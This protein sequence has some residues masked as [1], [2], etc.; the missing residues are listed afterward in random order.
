[1]DFSQVKNWNIPEGSVARVKD[2][3]DNVI[4]ENPRKL[5]I[6]DYGKIS[7]EI[8][9]SVNSWPRISYDGGT[10]WNDS[11]EPTTALSDNT[12]ACFTIYPSKSF[13]IKMFYWDVDSN[14]WVELNTSDCTLDVMYAL[15]ST[16]ANNV[17]ETAADDYINSG[18]VSS[19]SSYEDNDTW[20]SGRT[21]V[22]EKYDTNPTRA[23]IFGPTENFNDL[24]LSISAF[25]ITYLEGLSWTLS[26]TWT[27]T[28]KISRETFNISDPNSEG[29][30]IECSSSWLSVRQESGTGNYSSNYVSV[31]K[32]FSN[33]SRTGT[34]TLKDSS[35]TVKSTYT[36]TQ[37]A[38]VWPSWDL[39]TNKTVAGPS[40]S[41]RTFDITITDSNEVG[42]EITSNSNNITFSS[43]SGNG[44]TTITATCSIS[45]ETVTIKLLQGP[46]S[47]VISTCTVTLSPVTTVGTLSWSDSSQDVY[48]WN[49]ASA[50][51][52]FTQSNA[53][54]LSVSSSASWC[55]ASISG[56][57]VNLTLAQNTTSSV[58]ST[59][60]TLSG[61]NAVSI[62]K[63]ISQG[64]YDSSSTLDAYTWSQQSVNSGVFT[65]CTEAE[66]I[67]AGIDESDRSGWYKSNIENQDSTLNT[68]KI[69]FYVNTATNI[70]I[71]YFSD[72]ETKYD[73]LVA[74]AL[75]E[76]EIPSNSDLVDSTKSISTSGY[77]GYSN[78]KSVQYSLTAG[79]HWIYVTYLKDR[80]KGYGTD[81]GYFK[82]C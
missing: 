65:E 6:N 76:E 21:D 49:T 80:S 38:A 68:T 59:T 13:C 58:R 39:G 75:D 26:N 77:Q 1:M 67:A 3:N 52:S 66:M 22:V 14:S 40:G 41:V 8:I 18:T 50:T 2:S 27:P 30:T 37:G 81:S 4:W 53:G 24:V 72:G 42:W 7:N 63:T 29:W 10:T 5:W 62:T 82:I 34:I 17:Y 32:N 64:A 57:T 19:I 43:A 51:L 33:T 61:T 56:N 11:E 35:G 69:N 60:I 48:Y 36:I 55:S 78:V 28:Y 45:S 20:L 47:T 79:N 9:Y 54:T 23:C 71:K 74:T 16:D 25:K 12:T 31:T 46:S 70:T 44:T 73:Y 15:L